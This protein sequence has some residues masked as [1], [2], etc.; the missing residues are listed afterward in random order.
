MPQTNECGS[1]ASHQS[2]RPVGFTSL[3]A[4]LLTVH[5]VCHGAHVGAPTAN[6]VRERSRIAAEPELAATLH[7]RRAKATRDMS[8]TLWPSVDARS[9]HVRQSE[10][11]IGR[12]GLQVSLSG[13]AQRGFEYRACCTVD[14]PCLPSPCGRGSCTPKEVNP[15]VE[16]RLPHPRLCFNPE[17]NRACEK[18][19]HR[20][21]FLWKLVDNPPGTRA[22]LRL[23]QKKKRPWRAL[24]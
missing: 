10:A 19:V 12:V 1:T 22:R 23:R 6:T 4:G 8:R 20:A 17:L 13:V 11:H 7:H 14:P 16:S 3:I 15:C 2:S 21:P 5:T 9:R 24:P 18:A